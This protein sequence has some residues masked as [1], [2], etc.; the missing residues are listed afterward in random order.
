MKILLIG[1]TKGIETATSLLKTDLYYTHILSLDDGYEQLDFSRTFLQNFDSI[2]ISIPE[3]VLS[4]R[5]QRILLAVR[6]SKKN[7]VIM[8]L[9]SV[10]HALA[11]QMRVDQIMMNPDYTSYDGMILGI[12]H[13]EVGLLPKFMTRHGNFCNLAV[14]SQDLYYNYKTLEHCVK[15]Y[16]HKICKLKYVILDLFDYSYFNYDISKSKTAQAYYSYGG[17][18]LDQHHFSQNKNFT[19][20]FED[21]IA[22]ISTS[23][24]PSLSEGVSLW[25]EIFDHPKSEAFLSHIKPNLGFEARFQQVTESD[26]DCY[27][28]N[29]SIV[30]TEF[31]ETIEENVQILYQLLQLIYGINPAMKVYLTLLPRYKKAQDKAAPFLSSWKDF[32]EETI[33]VLNEA[34]P[35]H[36]LNLQSHPIAAHSEY[37]QDI[38]HFN[39]PGA[40]EFSRIFDTLLP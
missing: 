10:S 7:P 14:S 25:H 11:P 21:T 33:S 28:P 12:S 30:R 16:P 34:F 2:V 8:N 35:F 23:L 26:V 17:Y 6:G 29:T 4:L 1:T 9:F 18:R 3:Q 36:Y 24:Y 22:Q 15:Y 32:F 40:I 31:P 13:A 20:S 38:S 39:L 19:N 27:N 5:I 37:Y